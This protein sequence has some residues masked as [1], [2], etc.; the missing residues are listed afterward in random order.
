[1]EKDRQVGQQALVMAE[2]GETQGELGQVLEVKAGDKK[3]P[4]NRG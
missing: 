4:V 2:V 3:A 1:M